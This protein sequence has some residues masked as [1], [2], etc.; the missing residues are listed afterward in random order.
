MTEL[1]LKAKAYDLLAQ[2][3]FC[4]AELAKINNELAQRASEEAKSSSE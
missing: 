4:Q 3:Q 1:E 2:I